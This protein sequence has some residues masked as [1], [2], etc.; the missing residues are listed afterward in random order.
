[1]ILKKLKSKIQFF[2]KKVLFRIRYFLDRKH[3]AIPELA[4][5][6]DFRVQLASTREDFEGAF[7]LLHDDAIQKKLMN[8]QPSGLMCPVHSVLPLTATI[9]VK[10]KDVVVATA[11]LI[12]D[13]KVGFFSERFFGNELRELRQ[14]QRQVHLEIA[15]VTIDKGFKKSTLAILRLRHD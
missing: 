4:F 7:K 5:D 9:I 8:P 14:H 12:Q 2:F 3:F 6:S 10:Y 13:S 1:M 15:Y 11:A